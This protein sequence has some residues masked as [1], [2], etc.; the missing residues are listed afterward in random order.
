MPSTEYIVLIE[1]IRGT[2]VKGSILDVLCG[3]YGYISNGA[4]I[5]QVERKVHIATVKQGMVAA[6]NK[7][8]S[9][10]ICHPTFRLSSLS[11]PP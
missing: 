10:L 4:L 9:P 6:A 8:N 5:H 11:I 3:Y 7:E 1:D 2:N